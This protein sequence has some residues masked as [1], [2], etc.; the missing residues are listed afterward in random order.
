MYGLSLGRVLTVVFRAGCKAVLCMLIL[1]ADCSVSL[2]GIW[3]SW[4]LWPVGGGYLLL[5]ST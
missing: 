3:G 2:V 1:T 4:R 5:L